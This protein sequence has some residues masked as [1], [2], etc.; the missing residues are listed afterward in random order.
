MV[1]CYYAVRDLPYALDGAIAVGSDADIALWD[2]GYRR[3]IDGAHAIAF[4][5][6][7]HDGW[8]VQGLAGRDSSSAA[9]SS[10][11]PTARSQLALS[12]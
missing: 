2:P 8:Q 11:S 9:A 5:L 6:F 12:T 3:T 4:R 10:C 1:A 7:G